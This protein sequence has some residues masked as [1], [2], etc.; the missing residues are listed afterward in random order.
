MKKSIYFIT[1]I[2]V[3]ILSL[4]S[5]YIF[6]RNWILFLHIGF[7]IMWAMAYRHNIM[8]TKDK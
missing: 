4:T 5:Y 2:L 6:D 3:T 8:N 1:L 7:V